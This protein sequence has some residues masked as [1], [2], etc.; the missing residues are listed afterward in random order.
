MSDLP[1]CKL[2]GGEVFRPTGRVENPRVNGRYREEVVHEANQ[3]CPL[4][5]LS[6]TEDQWRALM[7]PPVVTDAMVERA[8]AE[9]KDR[10]GPH[11]LMGEVD[12]RAVLEAALKE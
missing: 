2:C 11:T 1:K 5:F 9:L 4:E 8:C 12:A 10:A 3:D 7:S 6:M